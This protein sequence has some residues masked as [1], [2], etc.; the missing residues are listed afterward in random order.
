METKD[1]AIL[2]IDEAKKINFPIKFDSI[3]QFAKLFP[4][5]LG[6]IGK[7]S[8]IIKLVKE[9]EVENGY[10]ERISDL[11][12]E[13][14]EKEILELIP[15]EWKW[16]KPQDDKRVYRHIMRMFYCMIKDTDFQSL[17]PER[18]NILLWFV[19]LHDIRKRGPPDV[20]GTF[21]Y[22]FYFYLVNFKLD[23]IF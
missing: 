12:F 11:F 15:S 22:T 2:Q 17:S 9:K 3:P 16:L 13:P 5:L 7:F 19:L 10:Y 6:G 21:K 1:D 23:L 18:Q 14:L 8:E 4:I 20:I